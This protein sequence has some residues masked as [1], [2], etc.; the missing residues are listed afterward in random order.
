MSTVYR[1]DGPAVLKIFTPLGRQ[2]EA[3]GA[4]A[5]E[6]FDG[7]GAARLFRR[8]DEALLLEYLEGP[9]TSAMADS[10]ATP[11]LCE[12]LNRLHDVEKALPVGLVS[13]EERFACLLEYAGPVA[14]LRDGAAVARELLAAPENVK[15]LH[16]DLHHENVLHSPRGWLAIDPKGL[17]GEST[18][19]AANLVYNPIRD[20]RR[21]REPAR[22][23]REVAV[24]SERLGFDRSRFRHFTLAYGALSA[25][26]YEEDGLDSSLPRA[27]AAVLRDSL[28]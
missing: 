15:V 24:I 21:V 7:Q 19:D 18:F 23:E 2:D 6:Y 28:R 13:L 3:S 25:C 16:G 1:V 11:I 8:S 9:D 10:E 17:V 20:P 27:V 12:V 4:T 14:L 22:I 5:L 26:W